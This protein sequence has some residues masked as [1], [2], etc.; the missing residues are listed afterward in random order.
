MTQKDGFATLFRVAKKK[1]REKKDIVAA[2]AEALQ[3]ADTG[4]GDAP[5]LDEPHRPT[6]VDLVFLSLNSL[7]VALVFLSPNS[8]LL[9]LEPCCHF[10]S[11]CRVHF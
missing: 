6:V 5:T 7:A 4:S 3:E 10:K 11:S 9:S 1:I 8:L 2:I